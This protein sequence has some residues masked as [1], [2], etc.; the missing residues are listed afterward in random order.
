[1]KTIAI[2]LFTLACACVPVSSSQPKTPMGFEPSTVG[3]AVEGGLSRADLEEALFKA[4]LASINQKMETEAAAIIAGTLD[5]CDA[6][7]IDTLVDSR[8]SAHRKWY[9][10]PVYQSLLDHTCSSSH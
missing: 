8:G 1:M 3:I 7:R 10:D 4:S 6:C 2:C 9:C 5:W